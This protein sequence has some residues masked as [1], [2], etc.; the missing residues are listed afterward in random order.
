MRNI[1]YTLPFITALFPQVLFENY[2]FILV[3]TIVIGFIGGWFLTDRNVFLKMIISQL[4]FFGILF[5]TANKN[6]S[7]LDHVVENLGLSTFLIDVTFILFNTLN[8]SL[9]FLFGF[10]FQ[11]LILNNFSS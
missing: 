3:C 8:I 6:I 4:I 7:Y 5:Y 1:K 11:K 2:T 9:L 10:K